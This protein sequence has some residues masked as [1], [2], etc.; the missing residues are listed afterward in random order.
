MDIYYEVHG[1]GFPIFLLHGN[2]E[3]RRI[4]DQFIKDI[5]GYKLITVDSRYHGKSIKSGE[6]SLHQMALDVKNIADELHLKEYDILGFSDGANIALTLASMDTRL[7]HMIL[8]APNSNPK[9]MNA[10]YRMQIRLTYILYAPFTLYNKKARRL[11]KLNKFMLQEP[12][13]TKEYL[14][15]IKVPALILYGDRDMIKKEDIKFIEESLP[16][17][18]SKMIENSSHFMLE[19]QYEQVIKEVRGFLYAAHQDE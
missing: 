17:S 2:Q 16:Y 14:E 1:E 10:F 15:T 5:K 12:N 13:F 18:V 6:L 7:K 9:G 4:Y 8:L 19:D 3:N 11:Q